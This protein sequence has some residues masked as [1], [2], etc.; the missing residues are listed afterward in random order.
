VLWGIQ[1]RANIHAINASVSSLSTL[2]SHRLISSSLDD[3]VARGTTCL[4]LTREVSL[5]HNLREAEG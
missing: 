3:R 4:N 5:T 1:R 2:Q